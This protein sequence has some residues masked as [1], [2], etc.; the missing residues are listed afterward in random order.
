MRIRYVLHKSKKTIV[1]SLE[2]NFQKRVVAAATKYSS[3]F[4]FGPKFWTC[5][6][7]FGPVLNDFGPIKGQGNCL[8]YTTR[9]QS[10]KNQR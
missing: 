6:K 8:L 7:Q 2:F 9:S 1:Y 5:V 10:M 4:W 3:Y